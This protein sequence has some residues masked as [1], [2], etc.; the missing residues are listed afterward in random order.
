MLVVNSIGTVST[1]V[2]LTKTSST[3][4]KYPKMKKTHVAIKFNLFIN[5]NKCLQCFLRLNYKQG[6]LHYRKTIIKYNSIL[7]HNSYCEQHRNDILNVYGRDRMQSRSQ[8]TE[9][10]LL[11]PPPTQSSGRNNVIVIKV[12]ADAP[13]IIANLL[14]CFLPSLEKTC[15]CSLQL[16]LLCR[17][18][19]CKEIHNSSA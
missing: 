5:T 1:S 12:C 16:L 13:Y 15:S 4:G 3:D 7:R 8:L 11:P 6:V 18:Q 17:F 2:K 9:P 10:P 14:V 19:C